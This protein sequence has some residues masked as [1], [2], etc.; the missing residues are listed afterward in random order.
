VLASSLA[1]GE[2]FELPRGLGRWEAGGFLEGL[3]VLPSVHDTQRQRPEGRLGVAVRGQ[4]RRWLRVFL[5]LRGIVGG[6]PE[7]GSPGLFDISRTFQNLSPSL[8]VEESYADLLLS[9]LDVRIGKQKIAWGR[10]DTYQPT[11]VVNPHRYTDPF[12]VTGEDAKI[13]IPAV[14][15]KWYPSFVPERIA[16]E[17]GLE[18]IWVPVPVPPRFPLEDERWF[19]ESVRAP[20]VVFLPKGSLRRGLPS[21]TVRTTSFTTSNRRPPQQLDEGAIASRL[22]GRTFSTDWSLYFYDGPETGLGFKLA[23]SVV[24]PDARVALGRGEKPGIGDLQHLRAAASLLP[25]FGRIRMVGAD[26]A[27]AVAGYTVRGEV[28]YGMDRLLPRSAEEF[29]SADVLRQAVRPHLPSI[30]VGLLKG[31]RVGVPL[32][33]FFVARD[34][35]EWGVGVDYTYRGWMAIAQVNELFVLN[36]PTELLLNDVDST[37]LFV[38]RKTF[39]SGRVGGEAVV[40]QEI[41]RGAT[42]GLGRLTY[43]ATD[44]L[45]LRIGYL[46]LAGSR[47]TLIGQFHDDDEAFFEVRYSF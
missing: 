41:E 12:L 42:M 27:F 23:T 24:A 25:R 33:D 2:T 37:L 8:E 29:L 39:L 46:L 7:H 36:N 20:P 15:A 10:L 16:A 14:R 18:L 17:A 35:V 30:I 32:P 19:P 4:P 28:A 47:R 40:M 21:V 13:G 43:A 5:D 3:A 9:R 45:R 44:H 26:C 38:L 1:C 34:T 31:R 6:P 22:D 11:D